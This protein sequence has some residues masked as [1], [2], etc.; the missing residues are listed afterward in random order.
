MGSG[1]M[2]IW[3]L[4]IFVLDCDGKRTGNGRLPWNTRVWLGL[5]LAQQPGKPLLY[6]WARG[7]GCLCWRGRGRAPLSSLGIEKN[8]V[9][10]VTPWEM[11]LV[12]WGM[13]GPGC[14]NARL[15]PAW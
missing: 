8:G 6:K 7:S 1:D 13:G 5:G 10:S 11:F 3:N 12:R 15:V 14:H 9:T 2:K 4:E